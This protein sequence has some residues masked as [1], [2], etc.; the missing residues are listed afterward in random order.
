MRGATA[1]NNTTACGP[2]LGVDGYLVASSVSEALDHLRRLDGRARV[3]AGGTDLVLELA[4]RES[5]L[6]AGERVTLVDV[7]GIDEL[8]GVWEADGRLHVGAAT[9]HRE[10]GSSALV[11]ERA[12]A[13]A[14]AALAVGSPQVREVGTIGGNV[15]NALPAADSAIAL[16]ALDAQATV[17]TIGGQTRTQPLNALYAGVG[18]STVDTAAEIV[19]EL[20]FPVPTASAFQRLARRKALALPI[21]NAAVALDYDAHLVCTRARIAVGPLDVRPWRALDAEQALEGARL[22]DDLLAIA[23]RA[24]EGAARCRDSVRACSL[25]RK[26][27]VRVLVERALRDALRG[28][29]RGLG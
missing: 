9:T 10:V 21:L 5:R 4:E 15:V 12:P 27:M 28:G 29:N 7:S 6:V 26:P 11:C 22:S 25:Y 24:A 16:T 17:A 20:S 3:V 1:H 18:R 13:L 2:A 14:A 19:T 23:A 8:R